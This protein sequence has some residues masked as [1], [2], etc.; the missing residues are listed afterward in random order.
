[1]Q[2]IFCKIERKKSLI[3]VKEI[4]PYG[5]EELPSN[6]LYKGARVLADCCL[7][8]KEARTAKQGFNVPLFLPLYF[9]DLLELYPILAKV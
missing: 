2:Q 4:K 6:A 1:M 5:E 9:S 8:E 7:V 3:K